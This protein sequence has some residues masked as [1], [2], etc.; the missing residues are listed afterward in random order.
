M[1]KAIFEESLKNVTLHNAK[2][3]ETWTMEINEFSDMLPNEISKSMGLSIN[4]KLRKHLKAPPMKLKSEDRSPIDWRSYMNPVVN[5]GDCGSGWAFAATASLEGIYSI[6]KRRKIKLSEQQMVDCD[7]ASNG[8]IGGNPDKAF[9]YIQKAGGQMLSSDY[10]YIENARKCKFNA[11]KVAVKISNI[12]YIADGK[13]AL[14][15]GPVPVILEARGLPSY[16]G[17]IF[18]GYCNEPDH[19]VTAVGWGVENG[20]EYWIMRNSWGNHGE[21]GHVRIKI[22]GRCNVAFHNFAFFY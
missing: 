4:G 6:Y 5:Q 20:I 11:S 1:R 10:P 13:F 7:I 18:N 19:A 21:A 14:S 17:G 16:K 9:D 2:D 15:Y 12:Y 3:N 22:D 8:C